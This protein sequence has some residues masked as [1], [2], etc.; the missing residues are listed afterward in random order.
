MNPSWDALRGQLGK[1]QDD[2]N[3][4]YVASALVWSDGKW[5][6]HTATRETPALAL[7]ALRAGCGES[8]LL[9]AVSVE[10][11]VSTDG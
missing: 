5:V 8:S 7:E 11:V 10:W 6:Q 3:G 9:D 4:P 2:T 1:L